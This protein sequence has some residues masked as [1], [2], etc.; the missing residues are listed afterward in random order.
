MATVSSTKRKQQLRERRRNRVRAVICGTA[1]RP[2]LS[3]F[4]SNK[5]TVAQLVNDVAG[6]TMCSAR[7]MEV[8]PDAAHASGRKQQLAFA[9]GKKLAEKAKAIGIVSVVFDRGGYRY[10]GR[11]QAVADGA[12]DGG[13]SF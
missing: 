1:E 2:R 5:H 7:D 3:V 13:L 8:S 12:R 11:V 4:R 6:T 9:L 10:H